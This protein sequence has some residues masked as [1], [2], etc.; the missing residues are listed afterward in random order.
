MPQYYVIEIAHACNAISAGPSSQAIVAMMRESAL[1]PSLNAG[2][3]V[4]ERPRITRRSSTPVTVLNPFVSGQFQT[5]VA[6]VYA[7]PDGTSPERTR[8]I[9][10]VLADRINSN[11]R[12][13]EGIGGEWGTVTATAWAQAV[14]GYISWWQSSAASN[15][16]TG[17][18][19]PTY[20]ADPPEN[21]RGPNSRDTRPGT[22]LEALQ[23]FGDTLGGPATLGFAIAAVGLVGLGAYGLWLVTPTVRA[24]QPPTPRSQATTQVAPHSRAA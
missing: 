24:L 14:N 13:I 10:S 23:G 4:G 21:P 19:Y 11:L 6:W 22:F 15:T 12:R 20:T 5:Y 1:P 3:W 7:I 16:Q 2:G 17:D 9:L 18:H 8:A